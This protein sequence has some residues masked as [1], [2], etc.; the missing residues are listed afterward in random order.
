MQKILA[1]KLPEE[2]LVQH[3]EKL[4]SVYASL[5]K[6]YP[7][8]PGITGVQDFYLHL[9]YSICLHDLGKAASGFQGKWG[10]WGYRHEILSAGFVG[11]LPVQD[12]FARKAIG[13]AII[14]HHR[15]IQE[16]SSGYATTLPY[17]R[18]LF[19][20]KRDELNPS[21]EYIAEHLKRIPHW[22]KKYLGLELKETAIP[23]S[24]EEVDDSYSSCVKWF[25]NITED[26]EWNSL[27]SYYGIFLR[28]F[29]TACDHLASG[30]K[31][32]IL[33]GISEISTKLNIKPRSFQR[34]AGTLGSS[35]FLSAPTGSGKTEAS[36][37]WAE[38]N[39]KNGNRI[40]YVLPYMASINAMYKRFC[41]YFGSENVNM[42]HSKASYFLYR[43]YTG[44]GDMPE[45][46]ALLLINEYISLT[47]KIYSPIKILTPF[48]ILKAFFGI[49][50]WEMTLSE[51]FN[52]VF[53]FDEVHVYSPHITA[54]IL[55]CLKKLSEM[56]CK[57]LFLS[58]TFPEFLKNKI[59]EVIP[60]IAEL[61]PDIETE[62]DK[63]LLTIARHRIEML[64]GEITDH[65]EKIQEEIESGKKVLVV[66][67]TVRRAQQLYCMIECED[68]KLLH[69]RF[70]L[71]DRE[72]IEAGIMGAIPDV[73]IATQVVEVSLDLD[74]DTIFTEPAPIDA[75]I[76]RFGRVN[77]K[78]IKGTV[79]VRVFTLGSDM[80][81]YFYN[82]ERVKKTIEVLSDQ[83]ELN[84]FIIPGL[85]QKVYE[86]GYNGKENDE[87]ESTMEAFEQVVGRLF[88]F[89]DCEDKDDYYELFKSVEVIPSGEV[90]AEFLEFILAGKY[91]EAAR[92]YVNI[93]LGQGMRL[94]H[95]NALSARE[96]KA[97]HKTIKYQVVDCEYDPELGLL[98]DT[99]VAKG[100]FID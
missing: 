1:K 41:G 74:F 53:I 19:L 50:G 16:L 23:G 87:Y 36:L 37:L 96:I 24:A 71:K 83:K 54:L 94:T 92:C 31:E 15:N 22:G 26:E 14:T 25:K 78:G 93:S 32:N 75:L 91:F 86:D 52:G 18:K 6:A 10:K 59:R 3:T 57:I 89:Y 77:R 73:L 27:H 66:C 29:L 81:K 67:N 68:K 40:F 84:E 82:A 28:G 56:N 30:G 4:L 80:D 99:I 45:S 38:R 70:I 21:L 33:E 35:V 48:Q 2:T 85:I 20:E 88:P 90:E 62:D 58:A 11:F 63:K 39:R 97:G 95:L 9:F 69:G 8:V 79:P 12:D 43:A 60:G 61:K 34:K 47:K 44:N 5:K 55:V 42:I 98:L 65:L 49:K 7:D 17:G 51:M 46:E 100:V 76:Q 13:L 72:R 64:E